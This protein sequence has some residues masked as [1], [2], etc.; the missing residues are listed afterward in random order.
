[1]HSDKRGIPS[2][3]WVREQYFCISLWNTRHIYLVIILL[4]KLHSFKLTQ[5]PLAYFSPYCIHFPCIMCWKVNYVK[6][7]NCHITPHTEHSV[8]TV[9][10]LWCKIKKM[11]RDEM[12]K[13]DEN[14]VNSTYPICINIEVNF[15]IH[16]CI[17]P[18]QIRLLFPRFPSLFTF[19][20]KSI[21]S[22]DDAK[23]KKQNGQICK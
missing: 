15:M 18:D 23:M 22:S 8:N 12:R 19:H 21:S 16:S 3:F 13:K 9:I 17:V 2:L 4:L 1:M 11:Y 7:W 6:W 14:V 5:Q 10:W 20:I